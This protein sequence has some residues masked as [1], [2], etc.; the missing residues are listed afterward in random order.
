M[1]F[2]ERTKTDFDTFLQLLNPYGKWVQQ[3]K[4]WL[5]EPLEPC[6]PMTEG[7]WVYT[8]FGWY[9]LGKRPY[10]WATDHYGRWLLGEDN[11]WRWKPDA[12]W[13][14]AKVEWRGTTDFIGW[15]STPINRY[16]EMT[17]PE[18]SRYA[19]PEEWVFV[20]RAKLTGPITPGDVVA[21]DKSREILDKSEQI[22]HT[23]VAWRDIDRSGPDPYDVYGVA[24]SFLA[25]QTMGAT[26]SAPAVD[27]SG[28]GDDA[29]PIIVA[30]PG[31]AGADSPDREK[32]PPIHTLMSLPDFYYEVKPNPLKPL[33]LYVYRPEIFQDADGV[34]RR[35][36]V[37]QNPP[38]RQA[39]KDKVTRVL[40]RGTLIIDGSSPAAT[41]PDSAAPQADSKPGS[42]DKKKETPATDQKPSPGSKH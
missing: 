39:N 36:E 11:V 34:Q 22:N 26:K 17:E 2:T 23:F 25:E 31:A 7:Q 28:G 12:D 8:D 33:D 9:W 37:W 27:V 20:P 16:G 1:P 14:P 41:T 19:R 18:A 42:S 10:S 6:V 40:E 3:N 35:V 21:A 30:A 4:V 38:A 5:Y 29:S 24:K 15:R 13:Q 32:K